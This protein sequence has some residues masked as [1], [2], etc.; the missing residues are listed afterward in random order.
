M[1]INR[2]EDINDYLIN[3]N[4]YYNVNSKYINEI[5]VNCI[6]EKR[7]DVMEYLIKYILKKKE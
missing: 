3:H 2:K 6:N 7:I 5:L 1:N 4:I